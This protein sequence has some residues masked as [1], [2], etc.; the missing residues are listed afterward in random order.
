M[1][2][3]LLLRVSYRLTMRCARKFSY[4]CRW[5]AAAT[6]SG[7]NAGATSGGQGLITSLVSDVTSIILPTAAG[8]NGGASG[9][10]TGGG[11]GIIPSIVSGKYS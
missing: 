1:E 5:L 9:T 4:T 10:N 3:E 8:G 11:Q 2:E 7:G 6:S